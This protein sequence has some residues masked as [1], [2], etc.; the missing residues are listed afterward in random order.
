MK[1]PVTKSLMAAAIAAL[2]SLPGFA[3][4]PSEDPITAPMDSTAVP[5][6]NQVLPQDPTALQPGMPQTDPE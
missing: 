2:I 5:E 3:A 4:E 6:E 1:Y